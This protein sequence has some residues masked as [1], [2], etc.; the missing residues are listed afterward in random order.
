MSEKLGLTT[1]LSGQ[2]AMV[3]G[4]SQGLGKACAIRLGECG[5]TV[6]CVARSAEKLA[7]TVAAIEAAGG[8]AVAHPCDVGSRESVAALFDQVE[9]TY[10][11]LDIIVNNAGITRDTLLPRMTDDQWDDVIQTNLTSCFLFCREASKIMMSARYGRIINMSSVSGLI[12][13]AGQTN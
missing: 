6:L 5:A 8:K 7:E 10:G 4:A 9:K 13:N 11:K 1:D 12:G 2:V 3:T